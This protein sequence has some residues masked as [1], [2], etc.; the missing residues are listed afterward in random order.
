[1]TFAVAVAVAGLAVA[2]C[3]PETPTVSGT[4][5]TPSSVGTPSAASASPGTPAREL[6]EAQLL[7]ADEIPV[8]DQ[9]TYTE[10]PEGVGRDPQALTVCRPE[11]TGSAIDEDAM[12]SRNFRLATLADGEP[13]PTEPP[14]GDEPTIYT[15][16]M[17]F[18]SDDAA[19]AA[20]QTYRDWLETCKDT[21]AERG[22]TA[23]GGEPKWYE[24]KTEAAGAAAGFSEVIWIPADDDSGSGYFESVG[25]GL[26][27]DRLAVTVSLVYGQDYIVAYEQ[28]GDPDTG[29]PPHPQFGLVTAA[30]DR[31]T[32]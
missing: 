22:D 15:Q 19:R 2:G 29:V 9:E 7:T 21:I 4:D 18:G 32:R 11:G 25:L 28:E 31:L 17:Q 24:V 6:T 16:V 8:V 20:H 23:A 10:T 5:P 27:G 14:V 26:V 3:S 1:M 13:A 30:T 12:L